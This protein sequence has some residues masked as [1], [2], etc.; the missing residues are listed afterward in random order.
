MLLNN[1]NLFISIYLGPSRWLGDRR[2]SS[3]PKFHESP[4]G[5]LQE[6]I[7]ILCEVCRLSLKK[8]QGCAGDQFH[9]KGKNTELG[10][11]TCIEVWSKKMEGKHSL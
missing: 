7:T 3:G 8:E 4:V 6:Q 5:E 1:N 2:V 9:R 11:E 10:F